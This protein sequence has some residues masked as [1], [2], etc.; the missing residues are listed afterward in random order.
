MF[1][2]NIDEYFEDFLA[3]DLIDTEDQRALSQL[4]ALRAGRH[5]ACG[6]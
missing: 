2:D 3:S 5:R 6:A 1:I 4:L